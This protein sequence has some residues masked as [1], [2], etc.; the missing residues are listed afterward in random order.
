MESVS[1]ALIYRIYIFIRKPY[2][3]PYFFNFYANLIQ[4]PCSPRFVGSLTLLTWKYY[5][6]MN[7][8]MSKNRTTSLFLRQPAQHTDEKNV[9]HIIIQNIK[10]MM[11][12]ILAKNGIDSKL[13]CQSYFKSGFTSK[14]SWKNPMAKWQNQMYHIDNWDWNFSN[15]RLHL[16]WLIWFVWFTSGKK[17]D[18]HKMRCIEKWDRKHIPCSEKDYITNVLFSIWKR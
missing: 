13:D 2:F 14:K 7:T 6:L 11:L 4:Y 1:Y 10:K 8:E 16:V 15:E 17:D 9:E 3:F 18:W 12:N 5:A